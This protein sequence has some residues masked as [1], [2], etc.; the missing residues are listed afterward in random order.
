MHCAAYG[1]HAAVCT[2]LAS[3][4]GR[5]NV[6]SSAEGDTPLHMAALGGH[7]ETVLVLLGVG[8]DPLVANKEGQLPREL[9]D[10]QG[11]HAVAAT[12]HEAALPSCSL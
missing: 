10:L 9:A 7:Q 6:A 1:G 11:W 12:L 5:V 4:G 2:A 8:A 3:K